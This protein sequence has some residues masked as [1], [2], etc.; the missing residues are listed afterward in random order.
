MRKTRYFPRNTRILACCPFR[1][2]D[3]GFVMRPW[4]HIVCVKMSPI[5]VWQEILKKPWFSQKALGPTVVWESRLA[6]QRR[7]GLRSARSSLRSTPGFFGAT[8][9]GV[10]INYL[11]LTAVSFLGMSGVSKNAYFGTTT[12][13]VNLVRNLSATSS[14]SGLP[15]GR[16]T[17][18]RGSRTLAAPGVSRYGGP[19]YKL[20][21]HGR[22]ASDVFLSLASGALPVQSNG[23]GVGD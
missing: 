22:K 14:S 4:H 5:A 16:P 23:Q 10:L 3:G 15:V 2:P 21:P 20:T 6:F 17:A 11:C 8:P 9:I 13:D 18:V 12:A 19:P 1:G 7:P